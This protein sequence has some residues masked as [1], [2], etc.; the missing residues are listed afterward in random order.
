MVSIPATTGTDKDHQRLRSQPRHARKKEEKT[1]EDPVELN[2]W[3]NPITPEN[4]PSR[5]RKGKKRKNPPA[6]PATSSPPP[7]QQ[8]RA[9]YDAPYTKEQ[10]PRLGT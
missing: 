7:P 1:R 4:S 6:P 3:G 10:F 9:R 2:G 5:R 8:Q